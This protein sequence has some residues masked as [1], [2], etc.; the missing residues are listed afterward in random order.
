MESELASPMSRVAP[1]LHT[2]GKL[3]LKEGRLGPHDLILALV[4]DQG[5]AGEMLQNLEMKSAAMAG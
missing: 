4:C 1:R 3:E 2:D 5:P